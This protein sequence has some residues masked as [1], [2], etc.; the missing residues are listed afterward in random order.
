MA[1][2]IV[3]V[4][5]IHRILML[6]K[7]S[8]ANKV[9]AQVLPWQ[10]GATFGIKRD[11]KSTATKSGKVSKGADP[12]TELKTTFIDN[13]SKIAD[14]LY[15]S[16]LDGDVMEAWI[17]DRTR[18]KNG[19][20][21]AWYMRGV[22]SDDSTDN[23]AD[24]SSK[25]ETTFNINYG[26]VRGWTALTN[27]QEAQIAYIFRGVGKIDSEAKNDGTDG[28]GAAWSDE[29]AGTGEVAEDTQTNTAGGNGQ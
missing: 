24:D 12:E 9:D 8:E 1:D 16:V 14:Q 29:D 23:D 21:F 17:V 18:K 5:G 27:E 28:N 22:V 13:W 4:Q 7:L 11:D 26:P 10:E 2:N 6:R 19:K 3:A 25:R 20:Y 15:D